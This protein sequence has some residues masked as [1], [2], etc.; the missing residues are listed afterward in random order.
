MKEMEKDKDGNI[1]LEFPFGAA[2]KPGGQRGHLNIVNEEGDWDKWSRNLPSQML[3]KQ[4]AKLAKQQLDVTFERR[5]RE[6]NEIKSLT[7]PTVRKKLMK[8]FADETDSASVHLK[9]ANLP[10]QTT[11]VILPVKSMKPHEIYAPSLRN[12]ERVALVRFPHGGTFEIPD[13]RVNN[14]NREAVKLFGRTKGGA[15]DAIG[16]HHSVADRL[17]GADFDGDTVL[18]IPNSRRTVKSTPAL[19]GLKGFDPRHSF[20]PHDGMRTIDGGVYRAKTRAVDY[21]GKRP[22]SRM[23]QQMGDISN[24]ITDMTIKGARPDEIARAV[25]HSMVIIDSEKHSLD[26][27][28]SARDNGIPALKR[29]YQADPAKRGPG[30][31]STLISRAKAK[32]WVPERRERRASE[33]GAIDPVTGRRVFVETGRTRVDRQGRV[34]PRLSR[35][36]RLEVVE[37]ARSLSSGTRM[38]A[39]YADHSN[40]LKDLANTARRDMIRTGNQEY[41]PSA[42]KVY[43]REVASLE[44]KLDVAL[45]NAPLERQAQ[46]L[47]NSVVSQKRQAHPDMD[48]A[49]VTKIKNQ[50]LAEMR[51]RTGAKKQ[52]IDITQS[53][54]DAIQAGAISNYKLEQIL[55]NSDLDTIR[56]LAAPRTP[57]LM[58]SA[59]QTRARSMLARGYTQA[60]IADQLGVS[61]TTLKEGVK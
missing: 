60:E 32:T 30:G 53:E 35:V 15:L 24:L 6:Y 16:I 39:L 14:R 9:A 36:K 42:N 38:E 23:Q 46:V 33:G 2:I 5:N 58:S 28:S 3:S 41:S 27:R 49:D 13:V 52:R 7:N 29:R 51:T 34:Q 45:R 20:P 8:T 12:G 61:L 10:R 37:D 54:W 4:D 50:A 17:S 43:H 26:F 31:A 21:G 22:T 57:L 18:V 25:R 55:N 44:S 47:A 56:K 59:M 48:P 40:R 19:Q 1:D 11:K